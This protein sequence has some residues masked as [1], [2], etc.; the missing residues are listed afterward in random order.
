MNSSLTVYNPIDAGLHCPNYVFVADQHRQRILCSTLSAPGD[1]LSPETTGPDLYQA[2]VLVPACPILQLRSINEDLVDAMIRSHEA[3]EGQLFRFRDEAGYWRFGL[4]EVVPLYA[5]ETGQQQYLC[6]VISR[7]QNPASIPSQ[8]QP[9]ASRLV[10]ITDADLRLRKVS[11]DCR[12]LG[13]DL[14]T[15]L[16]AGKPS[17]LTAETSD[18]LSAVCQ[19]LL[20]GK[21]PEPR[22]L[23]QTLR[24]LDG[25]ALSANIQ[26]SLLFDERSRITG[27]LGIAEFFPSRELLDSERQLFSATFDAVSE[28]LF[29]TDRS[30]F[31]LRAN[32]A[33]YAMT[34]YSRKQL[35]GIHCSQ[36]WRGRYGPEFFRQIRHSL[37]RNRHWRGECEFVRRD[38]EPCPAI[39]SFSQTYNLRQEVQNYVGLLMD[40]AEKKRDESRIYRL[41]HFD[42]LTGVANRHLFNQ[43][44]HQ[45]VAAARQGPNAV[46]VLFLDMDRFKPVNDSLGHSAGDQLLKAVA[47]RLMYCLAEGD[48]VAR[49]GGDEFALILANVAPAEVEQTAIKMASRVLA[50]FFAPFLIEGREVI[51]SCSIGISL[52]PHHGSSAEILLRSA[53]TAMYAAKRAGKNNYQFYDD[54]MNQRAM[55][56][57]LMEN[58]MRK[59]LVREEFELFFQPQ[60]SLV[61]G[62]LTGI[63]VLLRWDHPVFGS[64]RPLE[65]IDLAEQTDLIIPLGEW[66]FQQTCEKIRHWQQQGVAFA[67]VGINVSVNQFKRDDFADWVLFQVQRYGVNPGCLELEI[68]ESALMEDVEHSLQLLRKLQQ[69][70]IRIAVDDF[71]TGYSSLSYLRKFPISTL[72]IDRLFIEDIVD[73]HDTLQLAQ[74][75][76]AIGKSLDL[77]VI[78]EGV[79]TWEQ[80][81]LLKQ[82]GCD[83]VQGYYLSRAVA[84]PQ[85]LDL[86]AS[87]SD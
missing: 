63:E 9:V 41:A 32:P 5:G 82:Q 20:T 12:A 85:L 86:V 73:N 4:L 79:E 52:F 83:E 80:Y 54:A 10:W 31:I 27:I 58:A 36:I 45:A 14:P 67:R 62:A 42:S 64:V 40:I 47:Q 6:A 30:G 59:A 69:A 35:L 46:A 21:S 49:M 66:V 65:F 29:I 61:T 70:R 3:A 1:L 7:I 48:T 57:L 26:L 33:F 18:F 84:E 76:I 22:V 37:Q 51:S 81:Q 56:R 44:L 72:K 38:G 50:Q 11:G 2:H 60:Y 8:D 13:F 15:L 19:E 87:T 53:D 16:A 39:L 75:V 78:A 68:T 55:D 43:R 17:F 23:R 28:G 71:G 24:S 34:G 25:N 74:T 77:G